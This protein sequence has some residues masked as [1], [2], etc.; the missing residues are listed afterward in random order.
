MINYFKKMAHQSGANAKK[1]S[2]EGSKTQIWCRF[3][4][5]SQTF[6]LHSRLPAYSTFDHPRAG[7]KGDTSH[8]LLM[9][10]TGTFSAIIVL[11]DIYENR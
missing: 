11:E 4:E 10:T 3:T 2:L 6:Y 1:K 8:H 9:M 5:P 7:Q